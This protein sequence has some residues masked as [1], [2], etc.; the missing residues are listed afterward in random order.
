MINK[1]TIYGIIAIGALLCTQ[2]CSKKIDEFGNTN[3]NPN[4]TTSP[5]P[6]A[7]LT[8]VI[9]S[10]GGSLWYDAGGA[11]TGAGL[12]SQYFS[13]TQYTEASRYAKPSY[14]WDGFYFNQLEDLQN[15]INYNTDPAT[16]SIAANFGANKNQI[17][18]CR[19]LKVA[20]FKFISDEVGDIPYTEAL[21]SVGTVKYDQQST[22]YPALIAELKQAVDQFDMSA[23]APTGDVLFGGNMV[24]WQKYANSLRLLLALNL[25]KVDP[26]TGK[27]EFLAALGH[28]AGVI[29]S[30]ADNVVLVY[31]GGNYP[32][33][34]YN[35]YNITQRKDYAVSKTM[36]DTLSSLS[37]PRLA[38]YAVNN[39]GFPYGLT[40]DDAVT[41]SNANPTWSFV[42]SATNRQQATPVV[43]LGEANI[44]LARAEAAQLGWTGESATTMYA[45]G[46]KASM[47]QWGVSVG[48]YNT[49]LVTGDPNNTEMKQIGWQA[50]LAFYPNGLEGW[51]VYRRTGFPRL[52]PA[53]GQ[54]LLIPHR[55]VYGPNDYSL[56]P[57]NVATAAARFNVSGVNDSQWG[58][59]WWD[60]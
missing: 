41:F 3:N 5:I 29:S 16:A 19:I 15:I 38:A 8:N 6:S 50:W 57:T 54:A 2:S 45:N 48:S 44:D 12:Y 58:H 32:S 28:S 7:L 39:V 59:I 33:P 11:S 34:F 42:L 17:A 20:F 60:K 35:Y 30:S 43:L 47:A 51:N 22:V 21:K 9:S 24:Q 46:I 49:T 40:R 55:M 31:P 53:P 13:E 18:V 14:N 26:A 37:D 23:P 27:T 56:N 1:K 4:Q 25:E 52:R 36:I 10:L